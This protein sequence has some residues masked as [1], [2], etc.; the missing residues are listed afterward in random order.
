MWKLIGDK[1]KGLELSKI[2]IE[3]GKVFTRLKKV[4]EDIPCLLLAIRRS[5]AGPE[6]GGDVNSAA[7]P[8][9]QKP[10]IRAQGRHRLR[11]IPT[12]EYWGALARGLASSM[13]FC[14]LGG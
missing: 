14:A 4:R 12:D 9:L 2:S 7:Q 6:T 5:S 13:G 1:A 11:K 3:M 8:I 10:G